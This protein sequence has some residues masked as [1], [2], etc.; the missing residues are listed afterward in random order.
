[1]Y[2][3]APSTADFAE[4]PEVKAIK[5]KRTDDDEAQVRDIDVSVKRIR[6]CVPEEP[7]VLSIS[8]AEPRYHYPSAQE[9][10]SWCMG[11]PF[12]PHEEHLQYQTSVLREDPECFTQRSRVDIRRDEAAKIHNRSV[13]GAGTP[14]T[15]SS[16]KKKI[17]LSDYKNKKASTGAGQKTEQID[18]SKKPDAQKA[19]TNGVA[20]HDRRG[21]GGESEQSKSNKRMLEEIERD[22]M[23]TFSDDS[24]DA[25]AAK[26]AR[27]SLPS[28]VSAA[29]P[30]TRKS[31]AK[32]L[33]P[34]IASWIIQMRRYREQRALKR[35]Q[36]LQA[37]N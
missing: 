12:E 7:Y 31:S 37:R 33:R 21:S 8:A 35:L 32:S 6:K 30:T 24:R 11:T 25:Q 22:M 16:A 10:Y 1:M 5:R 36:K 20:S 18:P 34:N 4:A 26:K 17:S 23:S 15:N 13:S 19:H 29:K 3:S 9:A 28:P 14:M 27:R 2:R